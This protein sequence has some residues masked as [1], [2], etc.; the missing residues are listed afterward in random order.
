MP[1]Q[2][3]PWK[4]SHSPSDDP[5]DAPETRGVRHAT[6]TRTR[7]GAAWVGIVVA[8]AVLVLLIV[9][10]LQN[11]ALVEIA[12][13]GLRGTAPLSAT[14]LIAGVGFAIVTVIVGS[15]RIGQ[16]RHRIGSGPVRRRPA[17]GRH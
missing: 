10:M 2:S 3:P 1:V 17:D 11:T 12:F 8:I 6:V 9:F 13:F 16:L 14:L 15:R 4:P 7:T 5:G